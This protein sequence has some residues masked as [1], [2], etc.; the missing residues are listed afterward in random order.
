MDGVAT[1]EEDEDD[2]DKEFVADEEEDDEDAED[3]QSDEEMVDGSLAPLLLGS[4]G[5]EVPG[6]DS[7][8]TACVCLV[9][10]DKVIVA[11]AGDSRAVLCRN[12]KAVDLSVDHK[13]E[14]E[15]ETNR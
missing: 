5:A 9:G 1:E 7:G 2:S 15:V 13:P 12:G 3:E 8:T 11:N 10:K 14:D 6:E 4:G